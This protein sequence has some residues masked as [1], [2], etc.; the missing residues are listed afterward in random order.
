MIANLPSARA[1]AQ[2]LM[3]SGKSNMPNKICTDILF[4][5]VVP[6][7]LAWKGHHPIC[8]RDQSGSQRCPLCSWWVWD[9]SHWQ[10]LELEHAEVL[11]VLVALLAQRGPPQIHFKARNT[12]I[13]SESSGAPPYFHCRGC[14]ALP[15][16]AQKTAPKTELTMKKH[17]FSRSCQSSAFITPPRFHW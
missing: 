5:S 12:N 13:E 16:R 8:A 7:T 10:H 17:P 4:S 9:G 15:L 6:Q 2:N 1:G 14:S 11:S 3:I